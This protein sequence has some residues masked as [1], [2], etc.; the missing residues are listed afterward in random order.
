MEQK[1]EEVQ[2]TEDCLEKLNYYLEA[3]RPYQVSSSHTNIQCEV[4]F[5][6]YRLKTKACGCGTHV[7]PQCDL[8]LIEIHLQ[9]RNKDSGAVGKF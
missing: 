8:N 9:T 3:L 5:H 4:Q 2:K 6:L 7:N 1:I